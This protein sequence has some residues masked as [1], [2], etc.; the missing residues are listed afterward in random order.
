MKFG[1]VFLTEAGVTAIPL[2]QLTVQYQNLLIRQYTALGQVQIML[3]IK[4]EQKI[5]RDCFLFIQT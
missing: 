2:E 4:S 1:D 3:S 5:L